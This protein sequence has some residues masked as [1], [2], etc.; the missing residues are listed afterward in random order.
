ME[1]RNETR[2]EARVSRNSCRGWF[3]EIVSPV[4]VQAQFLIVSHNVRPEL[5]VMFASAIFG[6]GDG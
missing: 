2:A 5:A 6:G 4:N 3:R 1:R